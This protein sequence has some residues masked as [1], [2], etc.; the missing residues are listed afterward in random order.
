MTPRFAIR[1]AEWPRDRA[2]AASFIDGLQHYEHDIEPNRRIAAAVGTDYLDELLAAVD[3]HG[4]IVRIAEADG[5]AVGW[6]VAWLDLA[7]TYVVAE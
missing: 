2:A 3:R 6:V 5:R 1:P 4:G 7:E